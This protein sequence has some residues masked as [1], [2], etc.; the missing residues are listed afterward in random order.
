MQA[1]CQANICW[2]LQVGNCLSKCRCLALSS[3]CVSQTPSFAPLFVLMLSTDC[4]SMHR[5]LLYRLQ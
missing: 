1:V 4:C 5:M 2:A 3:I